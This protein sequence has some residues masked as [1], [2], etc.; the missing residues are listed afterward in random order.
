[1]TRKTC[2]STR[3]TCHLASQPF[4]RDSIAGVVLQCPIMS[5]GS[6][7]LGASTAAWARPLDIFTNYAKLP[8]VS[9][10]VAVMHGTEDTV[11]PC[12]NGRKLHALCQ[13]P[14]DPFWV[15]GYGHNDLPAGPCDQ[16]TAQFIAM[17]SKQ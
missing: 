1:M 6:V 7:L 5:G 15:E 14:F 8:L 11:V 13:R 10:P 12:D 16:Y 9:R 17:L 2:A 3:P 4:C